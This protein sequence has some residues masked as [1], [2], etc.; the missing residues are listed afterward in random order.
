MLLVITLNIVD[1]ITGLDL[2]I[3]DYTNNISFSLGWPK[4]D[5]LELFKRIQKA[6]PKEDSMKYD[7]RVNHL[8]W[9]TVGCST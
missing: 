5:D 4:P 9:E 1:R 7:S 3:I 8:D 2:Q 6:C